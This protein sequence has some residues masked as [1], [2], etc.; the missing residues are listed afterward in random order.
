MQFCE[1]RFV[2]RIRVVVRT[3]SVQHPVHGVFEI[4]CIHSANLNILGHSELTVYLQHVLLVTHHH[5]VQFLHRRVTCLEESCHVIVLHEESL[6][7]L[8][9]HL[10]DGV[11]YH[12]KHILWG[13]GLLRCI[14][15]VHLSEQ[16]HYLC[17]GLSAKVL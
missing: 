6:V 7:C 16:W 9:Q 1:C 2:F 13:F 17:I 4:A 14:L 11:A 10:P 12:G 3:L 5:T 8:T 15:G